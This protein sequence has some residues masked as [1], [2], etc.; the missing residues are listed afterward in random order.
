M[1]TL[2]ELGNPK[3]RATS[4]NI[5]L[6]VLLIAAIMCIAFLVYLKTQNIDL[7]SI[8]VK[9]ILKGNFRI[10]QDNKSRGA[11]ENINYD[12]NEHPI[13]CTYKGLIISCTSDSLQAMNKSGEVQWKISVSMSSPV[14]K[15]AGEYLLAAD[16][17][18][19]DIYA[20]E[21]K[22]VR[23]NKKISGKLINIDINNDG[24][25]TV[26]HD[27]KGYRGAVTVYNLQ[28]M[29]LFTRNIAE[30]FIL[31]A[32]V[33]P[34]SDQVLIDSIDASGISAG[35][36]F[37]FID[38]SGKPFAAKTPEDDQIF[39]SAWYINKNCILAVGDSSVIYFDKNR[40]QKWKQDFSGRKIFSSSVLMDKYAVVAVSGRDKPGGFK[41]SPAEVEIFNTDG[42][43]SAQYA[44]EDEV[45]SVQAFDDIIAASSN[46]GVDFINSRGKLVGK[47]NSKYDI[48]GVHFLNKQEAAVVTRGCISICKIN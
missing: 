4:L 18:G 35:T 33:S 28:G 36:G 21:G 42:K 38:M 25:T 41:S 23:W 37:E 5:L 40:Q 16:L 15:T 12:V 34:K 8:D 9:Q 43:L 39:P 22:E 47:Y 45:K 3:K 44:M 24:F 11:F 20:I 48:L 31:M 13:F 14:L 46:M 10:A 29:E 32:K 6:S 2:Q 7:S 1:Y 26:V 19:R 17:G 27:S 30:S